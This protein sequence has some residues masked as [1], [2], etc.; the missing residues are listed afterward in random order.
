MQPHKAAQIFHDWAA[1]EGLL[2]DGPVAPVTATPEEIATI[3]PVTELGKQILRAKQIQAIGFNGPRSEIVV[4]TKRVAPTSKKQ[5][6]AVPEMV[7][8]VPIKYRQGAQNPIGDLP[9][10]PFG[11]PAYIVRT[12]GQAKF[13]TCGSSVSVGNNRDA[14][15]LSCLVRDNAGVLYGLSNNHVTGS[16][17][18]AGVGLPIVAPGIFDVAPN[19]LPPFTLGFHSRSLPLVAGSADNVDPKAN[20]DA[21]LF[22]IAKEAVVSS[23]QGDSYDTPAQAG[24]L[25]DN[26]D[27]EKVGRTTQHTRGRVISQI[28]G[29]HPIQYGIPLYQFSGFVAFDPV[30]AIAGVGQLFSD[31]GDSGALITTVDQSGQRIAVGIVVGGK[32]DKSAPGEKLTIALP[33]LPILQGLGVTL[34]SGHNV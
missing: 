19:A 26:M 4:F 5:A 33:I 14:G 25:L 23:Y 7:D 20:L 31:N 16:C 12:I 6:A 27:V 30:F 13:Y 15:T 17:S 34:V 24:A 22:R 28:Y 21:A 9:P 18:Y 10:Q 29:A 11:G 3:K 2:P 32:N 8:D 1:M